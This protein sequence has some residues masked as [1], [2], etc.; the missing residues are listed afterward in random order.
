M[1]LEHLST[2]CRLLLGFFWLVAATS[3]ASDFG[4]FS[5][6]IREQYQLPQLFA[7]AALLLPSFETLLGLA[8]L[9]E[10]KVRQA[11]WSSSVLLVVFCILIGYGLSGGQLESC[12]CLG[13]F[14]ELTPTW[15]IVR[16]LALLA[17]AQMAIH[18]ESPITSSAPWKGWF[19][20]VSCTLMALAAGSSTQEP[21]FQDPALSYGQAMPEL[22]TKIPEL[23]KGPVAIFV[24]KA[25]CSKCWDAVPQIQTL[26]A[27][28]RLHVIGISPSTEPEIQTLSDNLKTTFPIYSISKEDYERLDLK[29]PA[30]LMLHDGILK[31]HIEGRVPTLA[32]IRHFT[33]QWFEE[34][35]GKQNKP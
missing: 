23:V 34:F 28:T 17:M 22:S 31:A 4:A 30:L 5:N 13:S 7:Y 12:G 9:I 15:A 19:L 1:R 8:L 3:K 32:S 24:F 27:E 2:G 35:L 26:Q 29:I 14:E 25:G 33:N 18:F 10:F 11:L 6:L 16:N 20:G 21:H